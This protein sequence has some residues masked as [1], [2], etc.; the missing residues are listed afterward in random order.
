MITS[1][2]P[3]IGKARKVRSNLLLQILC[4]HSYFGFATI[5][6]SSLL[7]ISVSTSSRS[8]EPSIAVPGSN[9][10]YV[11]APPTI[12]GESVTHTGIHVHIA[13]PAPQNV[14]NRFHTKSHLLL[15]HLM[16]IGFF[17][18]PTSLLM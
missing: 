7:E 12:P 5:F 2:V 17:F 3:K 6:S 11:E 14:N 1:S 8:I 10:F 15:S 4:F 13:Q 18:Y 16:K 9:I